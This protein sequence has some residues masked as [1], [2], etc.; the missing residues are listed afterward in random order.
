MVD[1]GER[2]RLSNET[3]ALVRS[4]ADAL[5]A[6]MN[7]ATARRYAQSFRWKDIALRDPA[8]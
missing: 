3:V 8:K 7:S 5:R 2:A 1:A 4:E 6:G